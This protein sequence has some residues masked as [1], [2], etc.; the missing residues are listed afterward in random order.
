MKSTYFYFIQIHP[1]V[2]HHPNK[3]VSIQFIKKNINSHTTCRCTK[4]ISKDINICKHIHHHS[5]NLEQEIKN[6]LLKENIMYCMT[7][8]QNKFQFLF[9]FKFLFCEVSTLQDNHTYSKWQRGQYQMKRGGG[10]ER[11]STFMFA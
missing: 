2:V 11:L 1:T 6:I 7:W 9:S 10:Q 8:Y 3:M 4:N 5:N